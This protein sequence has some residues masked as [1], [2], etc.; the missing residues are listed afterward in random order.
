[1][2]FE[3]VTLKALPVRRR[4]PGQDGCGKSLGSFFYRARPEDKYKSGP[5]IPEIELPD[6][7]HSCSKF[8][9]RDVEC[10]RVAGSHFQ[11]FRHFLFDRDFRDIARIRTPPRAAKDTLVCIH[12]SAIRNRKLA[13][14][15][16]LLLTCFPL[17]EVE[18]LAVHMRDPGADG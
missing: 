5:G 10:H 14:D 6:I 9:P 3:H 7:R 8:S 13:P 2:S 12:R 4:R 1:M 17:S 16:A 18:R 15:L 11:P